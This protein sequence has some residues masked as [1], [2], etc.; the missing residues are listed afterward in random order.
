M[1]PP[2][3]GSAFWYETTQEGRRQKFLSQWTWL[4]PGVSTIVDLVNVGVA[5][6]MFD[7]GMIG[8]H[9]SF[10]LS[11]AQSIGQ[12]TW[13]MIYIYNAVGTAVTCNHSMFKKM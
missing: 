1:P 2:W 13:S 3:R 11:L 5:T 6:A 12:S 7:K 8:R 10:L 9:L 4:T